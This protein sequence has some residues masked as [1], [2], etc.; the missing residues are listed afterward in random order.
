MHI[1][2]FLKLLLLLWKAYQILLPCQNC[3]TGQPAKPGK[4]YKKTKNFN[5]MAAWSYHCSLWHE[6]RHW[7]IGIPGYTFG[8]TIQAQAIPPPSWGSASPVTTGS[9]QSFQ[10][11]SQLSTLQKKRLFSQ[12]MII[13]SNYG[14]KGVIFNE[15][16]PFCWGVYISSDICRMCWAD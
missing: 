13:F 5:K 9:Q 12:F 1:C 6:H 8:S 14:K 7:G 11:A 15:I 3:P 10:W 2:W 4:Y 16:Y